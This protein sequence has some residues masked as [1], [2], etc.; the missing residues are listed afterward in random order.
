VVNLLEPGGCLVVNEPQPRNPLVTTARWAR[1]RIDP[2][3]SV[4]QEELTEAGLRR[5]L[6]GS[7][8]TS[9]EIVPQG[10]ISTPFAEVPLRPQRVFS[11]LARL[12]CRIDGALED[13]LSACL[14][15]IS[16]NLI[17]HARKP[18]DDSGADAAVSATNNAANQDF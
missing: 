10:V 12:A 4:N 3:Y 8:L 11:P 13:R 18:L 6:E 1:K 14:R 17:A 16:W 15:S 9:I 5:A 7:G 2:D